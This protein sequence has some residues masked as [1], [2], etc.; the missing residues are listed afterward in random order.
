MPKDGGGA[1]RTAGLPLIMGHAAQWSSQTRRTGLETLHPSTGT[2]YSKICDTGDLY[3]KGYA[4]YYI[5]S[6]GT[7]RFRNSYLIIQHF[8]SSVAGP[9]GVPE[10]HPPG[11]KE[12]MANANYGTTR[13]L[14]LSDRVTGRFHALE[15][16]QIFRSGK[17]A[18]L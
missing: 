4:H 16:M 13:S 11:S 6:F 2:M 12:L 14:L 5:H 3:N 8:M 17:S 1:L 7:Y 9:Q 10:I 18:L 15:M